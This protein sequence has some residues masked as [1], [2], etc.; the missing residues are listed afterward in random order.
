MLMILA[1][2]ITVFYLGCD[3]CGLVE[4]YKCFEKPAVSI[5]IVQGDMEGLGT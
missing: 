4:R 2:K 3:H 5:F 1:M